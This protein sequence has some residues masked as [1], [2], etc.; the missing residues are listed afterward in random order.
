VIEKVITDRFGKET[1]FVDRANRLPHRLPRD[2]K[3]DPN[4]V[5]ALNRDGEPVAISESSEIV[6]KLSEPINILRIYAKEDV[7]EEVQALCDEY[8]KVALKD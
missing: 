8:Y 1:V 7:E 2:M 6:R 4:A 3:E 5:L